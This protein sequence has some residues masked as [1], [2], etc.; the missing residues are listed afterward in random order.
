MRERAFLHSLLQKIFVG[1]SLL[2]LLALGLAETE[3]VE[4][5]QK[6]EAV[7][8]QPLTPSQ[9]FTPSC[10]QEFKNCGPS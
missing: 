2:G 3:V 7:T 9:N 1:L 4:L 8:A 10:D 6:A 5:D